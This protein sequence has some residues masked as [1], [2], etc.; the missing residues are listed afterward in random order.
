MRLFLPVLVVIFGENLSFASESRKEVSHPKN[1]TSFSDLKTRQKLPSESL[2]EVR[3]K[4][5]H[6]RKHFNPAKVAQDVHQE[7]LKEQKEAAP[8][9]PQPPLSP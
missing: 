9:H 1:Q 3:K 7:F 4:L 6:Y 8:S 2:L 5:P